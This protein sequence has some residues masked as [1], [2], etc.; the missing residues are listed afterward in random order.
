MY[1]VVLVIPLSLYLSYTVGLFFCITNIIELGLVR[2]IRAI[3]I[4][5]DQRVFI[6]RLRS[7]QRSPR[8]Q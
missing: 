5:N 6:G 2:V 4:S 8:V 3:L 1:L 7:I